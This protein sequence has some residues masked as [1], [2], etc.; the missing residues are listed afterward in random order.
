MRCNEMT[1]FVNPFEYD[2][3]L[4]LPEDMILAIYVEDH[5]Y[6]RFIRSKRNVFYV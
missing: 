2:A 5:N 1:D 3:A 6:T 4:N